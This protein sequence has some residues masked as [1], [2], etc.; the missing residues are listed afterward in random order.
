[1]PLSAAALLPRP[2]RT[3]FGRNHGP[4][5]MGERVS[6]I[7]SL[8]RGRSACAGCS[9]AAVRPV[10]GLLHLAW[11]GLGRATPVPPPPARAPLQAQPPRALGVG[12]L[13]RVA[14]RIRWRGA[15]VPDIAHAPAPKNLS[16]GRPTLADRTALWSDRVPG[17]DSRPSFRRVPRDFAQRTPRVL[18]SAGLAP[19]HPA[20]S[21][22]KTADTSRRRCCHPRQPRG[23]SPWAAR[24]VARRS[25]PP[26]QPG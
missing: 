6:M 5:P 3:F 15:G 8:A 1:M 13:A 20:G 17:R 16:P 9:L 26:A 19:R 4:T 11:L 12:C 14:A 7:L 10:P 2:L 25:S 24:S 23:L 22:R 18:T 21:P